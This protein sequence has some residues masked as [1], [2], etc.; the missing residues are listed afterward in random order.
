LVTRLASAT[1]AAFA[2]VPTFLAARRLTLAPGEGDDS[3]GAGARAGLC[4]ALLLA[5]SPTMIEIGRLNLS[6]VPSAFWSACAAYGVALLIER[7]TTRRYLLTGAAAGLAAVSKYPAGVVAVA[8]AAVWIRGVVSRRRFD[9]G[10]LWAG[11]AAVAAFVVLM[12]S[13]LRWPS[14]AFVGGEGHPDIFFGV[15][16]YSGAQWQGVVRASNSLYYLR[17]LAHAFGWPALALGAAGIATLPSVSRR[18]VAWML[19]FPI[20]HLALLLAMAMAVRR[21]LMPLLP[22]LAI[23]L[24]SGLAGLYDG[25]AARWRRPV[26]AAAVS[27]AFL[28]PAAASALLL[29]RQSAPTTRDTAAAWMREHLPPGSFLVQEQYTPVVGPE[30]LFPARRP[31][32]AGRLETTVLR[33]PRHDYLLLSSEAYSRFLEPGNLKDLANHAT[34]A[35]YREILATWPLVREW[36]PGQL[37]DGPVLRL[38]RLD[39]LSVELPSSARLAS[40]DALASDPAMKTADGEVIA[41]AHPGQWVLFKTD[42]AA[43]SYRLRVEDNTLDGRLRMRTREREEERTFELRAGEARIDVSRDGRVFLYLELPPGGS[44][45]A[46]AIAGD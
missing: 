1:L 31:R 32:F 45:R 10:L 42:L 27:A 38:Y 37:Q 40:R 4:A 35:R 39:S 9:P 43:G 15:R 24:G 30:E 11:A 29:V 6:D 46:L 26:A 14:V 44:V 28:L 16:Q 2:T 18:R 36:S 20:F 3:V 8:I 33:D 25:C 19:P 5:L 7:E 13:L 17:E 21:N 34:A 41:F 23:T 12:P 22:F